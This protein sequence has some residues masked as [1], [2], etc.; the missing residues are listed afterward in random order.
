MKCVYCQNYYFSQLDK[1]QEI[2]TDKLSGMM[3]E[4]EQKGCHN[5]NL[6]TPTHF[7]PQILSALE[8][9]TEKGLTLPIVY[10]TSGYELAETIKLLDG[11]VDIYLTDMRYSDDDM[12]KRYSDAVKYTEF[13]RSA[14]STMQQQVGDLVLDSHGIAQRGLII[15]LLALPGDVSGIKKTL[16]FIKDNISKNT[17]LSV[18]SQYYPTYKAYSY[19]ELSRGITQSEYK[20]IIDEA[21]FLGLNNGW[22]QQIPSTDNS[23][24]FGTSIN[25]DV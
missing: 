10:N 24:Y 1:G 4:L 6:V 21:A 3:L 14:V 25:P 7:V 5:I 18:M 23:N 17:H 9:A 15:R 19:T 2:S 12:A 13:N 22:I 20:F 11:V 16:N 8:M